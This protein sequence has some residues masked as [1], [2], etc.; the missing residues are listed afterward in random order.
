MPSVRTALGLLV[1]GALMGSG[2]AF[3]VTTRS[4]EPS[5]VETE[6][7]FRAERLP[8]G[9]EAIHLN[10]DEQ[11]HVSAQMRAYLQG[12]QTLS[13]AIL[14]EDRALI[15]ETALG[16]S[17]GADDATGR[18]INQKVPRAFRQL[19]KDLRGDFAAMSQGASQMPLE[20]VQA[21]MA[22][23]LSRCVAC[24]GSYGVVQDAPGPWETPIENR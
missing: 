18:A 10:S 3:T 19:G 4:P 11:D 23:S 15:A 8:D 1:V 22:Q 9:R 7:E 2:L 5:R 20:E 16:L 14:D 17:I 21:L 6:Q 13:G 12:L 24:H